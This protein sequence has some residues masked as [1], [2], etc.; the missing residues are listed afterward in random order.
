MLSLILSTWHA[1]E[2]SSDQFPLVQTGYASKF[3]DVELIY[4]HFYLS[5]LDEPYTEMI[6][7]MCRFQNLVLVLLYNEAYACNEC[8]NTWC[9]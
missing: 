8:L 3:Q 2:T 1:W 9:F 7:L 5:D 6:D 4:V